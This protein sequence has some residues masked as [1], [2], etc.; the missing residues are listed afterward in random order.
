MN[1]DSGG[2]VFGQAKGIMRV[3]ANGGQPEVVVSVKD[4]ELMYGPQV[5]PGGEWL[6]FTLA[7]A[8]TADSWNK[9]QIVVQSLKSSERKTLVSGG[10]DGRYLPTGHLVYALGGV[11]FAVPFDLPRLAVTGGPVP[12][13]EGVKRS[14]GTTGTAH[15]SVS[16]TGSLV[17][18][19]GPASTSSALSDLA[20]IDRNGAVQP[21]KLPPHAYEYPRLSPDGTR[22]AVGSDDGK[23]AIVWIYDVAGASSARRLTLGGR[24]RVPVWSADGERVAF[25]SDRD[26]DLGLFWQR[27]DGA[28]PA[29]RLTKP[30]K[31][32][33][34]VPESWSPD[35][36]TLL[37]SVAKGSSYAV[38]ALSLPDKKVT[39][40]SGIQSPF[41]PA[42]TFSPD[43]RW[44]TYSA[45]PPGPLAV[46]VFV[47]PFPTTG[48]TYP[49][50]KGNGFHPMWS[51]DGKELFY[52]TGPGAG[53]SQF[54]A[55]SVTTRPTFTFG[56]PV[57]MPRPA[58]AGRQG[59]E[60]NY[61]ITR[62][63]K[64]FL[65]V[66]PAGQ[67]TA[68]GAPAAPQIQV[69]LNW[70]EELKA[71]NDGRRCAAEVRS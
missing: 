58:A 6:L 47:Q 8:A 3:S 7:T 66:V 16:S 2:I 39:P 64:R 38:A 1:W 31:D 40:V 34:H 27:A 35:G 5:L 52:F 23:E 28:T 45:T 13:V 11:L 71:R 15:F 10:S 48:A 61:D 50:S 22:I 14:V 46:S 56:N 57:S 53:S 36:K 49:I 37:F 60:R 20:L 69:V 51:P 9:A 54:V 65:G 30:D 29:E 33:A 32:T 62:D 25:Q 70:F 44:V 17:F 43:G 24:N 55:V 42:A 68:S 21:L 41:P 67:N 19:P 18:V 26:G 59:E 63:G 4:G 12:I